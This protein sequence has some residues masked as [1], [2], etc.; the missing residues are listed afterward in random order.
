MEKEMKAEIL[1]NTDDI[2]VADGLVKKMLNNLSVEELDL[3]KDLKL[4]K[5]IIEMDAG[6]LENDE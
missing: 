1:I 2:Y 6:A 5:T 3:I 4:S